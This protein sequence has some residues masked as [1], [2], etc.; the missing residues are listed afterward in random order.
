[1]S[2]NI[3]AGLNT[4]FTAAHTQ[5]DSNTEAQST[6]VRSVLTRS[7]QNKYRKKSFTDASLLLGA[8]QVKQDKSVLCCI[9]CLSINTI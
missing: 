2:R 8:I 7:Q 9:I 6:P 5:I 1:M 3:K 4:A